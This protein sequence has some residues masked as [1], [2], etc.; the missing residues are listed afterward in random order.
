MS[1]PPQ[2]FRFGLNC[3]A[4]SSPK[5]WRQKARRA[6][7]LGYSAFVTTDHVIGPGPALESTNHP[8]QDIACLPALVVAAEATT[9]IV[10]GS[11]VLCTG[12]RNPVMLAKEAATLDWFSNGRLELG[13]GAGWMRAEFEAMG[14]PW[15]TPAQ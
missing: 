1:R 7:D 4:A 9:D 13:L 11:R 12:Y 15:Q 8:V 6:E 14:I 5:E 2:P 3:F 10:I